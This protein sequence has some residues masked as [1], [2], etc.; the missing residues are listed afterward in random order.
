MTPQQLI[1]VSDDAFQHVVD[2]AGNIRDKLVQNLNNATEKSK[3]T[4]DLD[5]EVNTEKIVADIRNALS[6]IDSGEAIKIN[7][8]IDK[9]EIE[10]QIR[11]AIQGI[12]STNT[13]LDIDINIDKQSIEATA[14]ELAKIARNG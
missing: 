11:S 9:N 5:V 7:L 12:S 14:K 1:G 8:D 13:P 3:T 4:F 2:L 10:T 6:Q